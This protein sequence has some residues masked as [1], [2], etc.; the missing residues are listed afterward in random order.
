MRWLVG[1]KPRNEAV[2]LH[3][4]DCNAEM[5]K[6]SYVATTPLSAGSVSCYT[7]CAARTSL[8]LKPRQQCRQYSDDSMMLAV[9]VLDLGLIRKETKKRSRLAGIN[10]HQ[11]VSFRSQ[12]QNMFDRGYFSPQRVHVLLGMFRKWC[13]QVAVY[14]RQP[15]PPLKITQ[16]VTADDG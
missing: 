9:A 1:G 4:S 10:T 12:H 8:G 2:R 15:E 13:G 16:L 7:T 5:R 11:H 14:V 3:A 6:Y